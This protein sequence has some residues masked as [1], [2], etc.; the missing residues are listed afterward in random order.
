M[1]DHITKRGEVQFR[2]S[3]DATDFGRNRRGQGKHN[4]GYKP[5]RPSGFRTASRRR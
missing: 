4:S 2:V 5:R 3:G 1:V